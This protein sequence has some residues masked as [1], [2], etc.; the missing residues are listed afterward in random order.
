MKKWVTTLPASGADRVTRAYNDAI[1]F[2]SI[3]HAHRRLPRGG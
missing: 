2:R 3:S 1:P